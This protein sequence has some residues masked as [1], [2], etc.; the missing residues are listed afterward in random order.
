MP[1]L[2]NDNPFLNLLNEDVIKNI[3]IDSELIPAFKIV[4][5]KINDYFSKNGLM[6]IK[7]WDIFFERFLI[8]NNSEQICIILGKISNSGEPIRGE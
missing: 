7:D 1:N 5:S 2:Q 3:K 4:I 8:T 6:N